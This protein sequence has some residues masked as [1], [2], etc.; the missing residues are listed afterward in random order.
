M[1]TG[2]LGILNLKDEAEGQFWGSLSVYFTAPHA[3]STAFPVRD[4][5]M[6][7]CA[8]LVTPQ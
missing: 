2:R 5:T 7:Y 8:D 1:V 3:L 4:T 6:A